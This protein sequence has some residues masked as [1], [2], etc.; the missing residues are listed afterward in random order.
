MRSPHRL[1]WTIQPQIRSK[2]ERENG[3]V[4][5]PVYRLA[6]LP[7]WGFVAVVLPWMITGASFAAIAAAELLLSHRPAT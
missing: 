4:A 2:S 5:M 6:A 1:D 3:L 7:F